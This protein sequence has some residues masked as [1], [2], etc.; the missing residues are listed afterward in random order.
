MLPDPNGR[1]T[2]TVEEAAELLSISRSLAYEAVRC[3][4]I[5]SIRV[6][7]RLLVPTAALRRLLGVEAAAAAAGP[8]V[9]AGR[10]KSLRGPVVVVGATK[11]QKVQVVS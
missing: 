3:G 9:S 1:P 4:Q 2:L 10:V 6:G 5:P 11:V 8:N 7:R